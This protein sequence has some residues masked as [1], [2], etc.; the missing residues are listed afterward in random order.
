MNVIVGRNGSGKS[1][2]FWA[3]RFVLGDAYSNMTREERQS[4]LHEGMQLTLTIIY[5]DYTDYNATTTLNDGYND[6]RS[7]KCYFCFC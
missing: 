6:I 4:L 7:G 3:I 2:F 1:N 5:D